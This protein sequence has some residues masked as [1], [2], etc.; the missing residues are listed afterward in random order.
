MNTSVRGGVLYGIF[1]V[2]LS[3][4]FL[5][6]A[7]ACKSQ[8]Y[9]K[10]EAIKFCTRELNCKP[11]KIVAC[12]GHVREWKCRCEIPKQE[13]SMK[14]KVKDDIDY[15]INKNQDKSSPKFYKD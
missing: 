10:D 5:Q 7:I 13:P 8:A 2:V 9:D 6:P 12:Y 15:S 4:L 1:A 14:P 11:P 3:G